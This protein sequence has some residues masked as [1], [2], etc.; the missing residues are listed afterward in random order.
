MLYK[1]GNNLKESVIDFIKHNESITLFS[2]YI[3]LNELNY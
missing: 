2:A 1:S 3:K